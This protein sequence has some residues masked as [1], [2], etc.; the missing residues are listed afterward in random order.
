MYFKLDL[1]ILCVS[2]NEH[3]HHTIFQTISSCCTRRTSQCPAV[4]E[5]WYLRLLRSPLLERS[6]GT[7]AVKCSLGLSLPA[8]SALLLRPLN[9]ID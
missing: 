5:L 3:W 6:G 4:F 9:P 7:W 1:F 8:E 2:P